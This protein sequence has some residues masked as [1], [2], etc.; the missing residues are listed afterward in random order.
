MSYETI[1]LTVEENGVATVLL[2]RP[3]SRNALNVRMCSELVS[4]TEQIE[5]DERIRVVVF[6]GAGPAFCAGADLKERKDMTLSDMTARRVTGFAAYDAI[7]K[8]S[9]PA[10][11]LVHGPAFGSGCEII[12]A[13]DFAWATPEATFR[14]PE[15]SWGTVGA[16]QR[17][18]RIAGIRIAKEL[19]FSGRVFDAQQ[20]REYG[21]INRIVP[22]D[23][24]AE[25]LLQM[26]GDIA[27]AKPLTVKLT[28]H[29]INA[30]VETTR[31]GAM[32]IEL[33]AI[34]KN[35]RN[36][37]WKSAISTFGSVKGE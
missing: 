20:A 16:T 21:L 28:K 22:Q 29:C 31:E 11:A 9:R 4:V 26:A 23:T 12:A 17:I 15:V 3:Q 33:L 7:E 24:I 1:E 34:E 5:Q 13:C 35:L 8:L 32:A 37:D 18:S 30:G 27:N 10:I 14:Y 6:R 36:S 25:Q 2:N 19:L